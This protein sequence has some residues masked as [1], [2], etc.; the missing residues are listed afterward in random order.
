M[1]QRLTATT[2]LTATK[3]T[4][5]RQAAARRYN[6]AQS[7]ALI[8]PEDFEY[9]TTMVPNAHRALNRASRRI[10]RRGSSRT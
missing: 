8:E 1:K 5:R 6:R 4:N 3:I 7:A 9:V 2:L 10:V